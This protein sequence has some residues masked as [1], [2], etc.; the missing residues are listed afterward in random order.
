[1]VAVSSEFDTEGV[2]F[3]K[4]YQA[5]IADKSYPFIRE[6]YMI[7][8]ETFTGLGSGFISFVASD[9]GQR[10]ILKSK[11]VPATMP[12]RLVEAKK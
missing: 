5:Y 2:E 8:R 3:T 1:V 4:P 10:I 9:P 7:S 12:V 6:V 11:L